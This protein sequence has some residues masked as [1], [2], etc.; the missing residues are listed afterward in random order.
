MP[1]VRVNRRKQSYREHGQTALVSS[2][3]KFIDDYQA[4]SRDFFQ[5]ERDLL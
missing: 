2:F 1:S 5:T 4:A 3:A